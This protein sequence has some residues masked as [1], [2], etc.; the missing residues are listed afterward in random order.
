MMLFM[1]TYTW[2]SENVMEVTYYVFVSLIDELIL[3]FKIYLEK[4]L[5][6]EKKL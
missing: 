1:R 6:L 5:D 3:C 4:S 2:K